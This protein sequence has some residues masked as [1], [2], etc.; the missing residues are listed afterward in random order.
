MLRRLSS[1]SLDSNGGDS[2]RW[3]PGSGIPDVEVGDQSTRGI[4]PAAPKDD[5]ALAR[6]LAALPAD[7]ENSADPAHIADFTELSKDAGAGTAIKLLVVGARG[8]LVTTAK[9]N[10]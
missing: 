1:A 8:G 7:A 5:V 3:K 10:Q 4:V 6:G 9:S 2:K